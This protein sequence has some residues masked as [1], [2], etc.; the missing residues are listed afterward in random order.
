MIK[1]LSINNFALIGET[2]VKFGHGLNI[3]TGETGAGKSILI[4]AID[5]AFGARAAKEQIKTGEI[6]A[7]IELEVKL[8]SSFP[9]DLLTE[10][11]IDVE[12]NT[13]IISREI[14]QT[15]TRSRV[16]GVLVTQSY[17]QSLREHLI[18]IH[19]QHETYNYLQP[20][21]HIDLLDQYGDQLHQKLISNFRHVY[22]EYKQ[23]SKELELASSNI[24]EKEQKLDFLRFQI[25]EIE[26]AGIE[27]PDEYDELMQE[28][29]VFLNSEELKNLTISS[30][31]SLYS[32]D[33]SIIDVLGQI[34]N[35]LIKASELDTSL[36]DYIEPITSS[37][38]NLK[39]AADGLRNYSENLETDQEKLVQIEE[40]IDI[41]DKLK[42]KY[43]PAL[44]NVIENLEN[45]R[46]ELDE[47]E[48]NSGNIEKLSQKLKTLCDDLSTSANELS[49]SRKNLASALSGLIQNELVKLE[50][51]K[52]Q[53]LVKAENKSE[54]S[55]NG[56]DD[57]E[58]LISP[59]LGEP[60]KPLA[61]IASGG[62]ISRVMLAVKTV[63]ANADSVDTVIFDEIDTGTSGKTSQVIAEEL[64]DLAVS[65][66]ILCITHQPIIAA[67]ADQ[68]FYIKKIQSENKTN[69][70]IHDLDNKQRIFAISN[71]ASGSSD[72]SDA[73]NF[74]NKLLNQ[75]AVYKNRNLSYLK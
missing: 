58:F 18:D 70:I 59:N 25:N 48:I 68:Y 24:Q 51:P 52:V 14:N 67:M 10:N 71:L 34:E 2:T 19:S 56:I 55:S 15:C 3:L 47:I 37:I 40:R 5:L 12:N 13:L 36:S 4:D 23:V 64:A 16:N 30:Y 32:Q 75:A 66:Q 62:E 42:R 53:F 60:L 8:S 65:H 11:G 41:L 28:R 1:S 46:E 74:A 17:V 54:I 6:K 33:D 9:V 7:N 49:A 72:D 44:T 57:I 69:I 39:D 63:L 35:R 26:E 73:V 21:K 50:M 61:K 29:S 45:F 22:S 27:N 43:G 38:I 20:K 31:N